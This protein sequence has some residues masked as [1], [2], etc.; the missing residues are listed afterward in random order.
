MFSAATDPSIGRS[1]SKSI[2]AGGS[3]RAHPRDEGTFPLS[4]HFDGI[5]LN[6]SRS[7]Q[8]LGLIGDYEV[9]SVLNSMDSNYSTLE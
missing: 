6:R 1:F 9:I 3:R 2:M 5:R 4:L 7:C 8:E